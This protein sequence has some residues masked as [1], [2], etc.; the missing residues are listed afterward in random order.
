MG[1]VHA[2]HRALR[3]R[4]DGDAPDLGTSVAGIS[5]L[6]PSFVPASASVASTSSV[7]T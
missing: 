6:A 5:V 1:L 7:E 4:D 2:D 3:V